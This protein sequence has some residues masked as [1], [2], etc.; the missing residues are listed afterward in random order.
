MNGD[1]VAKLEID[2][3]QA[4][5]LLDANELA[6]KYSLPALVVHPSLMSE[7]LIIRGRFGGKYK[8]I[9]AVDW[10]RGEVFGMAKMHGLSIDALEADGYEV[11]LTPGKSTTDTKN[12]IGVITE[13][14]KRRLAE[15]SEV[16]FV[17][18]NNGKDVE[19]ITAMAEALVGNRTPSLVRNDIAIK[20][21][22]TNT[23]IDAFKAF[24]DAVTSKISVPIKLSGNING[25]K[26]AINIHW[27]NRLAVNV[28]QAKSIIREFSQQP[29]ASDIF[30]DKKT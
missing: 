20:T 15:I 19:S 13:F 25:I 29:V 3:M 23:N 9:T 12:E 22:M 26:Q 16:R 1:V 6:L 30:G 8:L 17:F 11:I 2:V 18:N 14:I 28:T 4:N 10:P 21:Q 27:A 5:E 24:T 7:A